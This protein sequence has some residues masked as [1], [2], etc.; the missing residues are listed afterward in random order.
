MIPSSSRH[1]TKNYRDAHLLFFDLAFVREANVAA[2][3]LSDEEIWD[4]LL[5]PHNAA[6][7]RPNAIFD[8]AYY[9]E[10]NGD[11]LSFEMRNPLLHYL[12][13]GEQAGLDPNPYFDLS[14]YALHTGVGTAKYGSLIEHALAQMDGVLPAFHPFVDAEFCFKDTGAADL[15]SF[16]EGLFLGRLN[17][18]KPHPLFDSIFLMGCAPMQLREAFD[19]YW[20][21][22]EDVSTHPLFDIAYYKSQCP[23]GH[24]IG[25]SVYHYLISNTPS[26]PH[27]LFDAQYYSRQFL[28]LKNTPVDSLFEH[29]LTHGKDQE[30]DPSPFFDT[31]FYRAQ[32]GNKSATLQDYVVGGFEKYAPHPL[33]QKPME[34]LLRRSHSAPQAGESPN[35]DWPKDLPMAAT[36]EFDSAIYENQT[37]SKKAPFELRRDYLENGYLKGGKPNNLLAWNYISAQLPD[38]DTCP[39]AV[40]PSYFR[41]GLQNRSRVIFAFQSLDDTPEMRTWLA[42]LE[43]QI[44]HPDLEIIVVTLCHGALTHA[45]SQVSHIWYLGADSDEDAT[46]E[47]LMRSGER[48]RDLLQ[49]NPPEA[50]FVQVSRST[51]LALVLAHLDYPVA[52]FYDTEVG[53][54]ARKTI[55]VL[56]Q[57]RNGVFVTSEQEKLSLKAQGMSAD[58]IHV[59][60]YGNILPEIPITYREAVRKEVRARLGI[61]DDEVLIVSDGGLD[62]EGGVDVFGAVLAQLATHENSSEGLRFLWHGQGVTHAN[63]PLFYAKHFL[64]SVG[65]EGKFIHAE[66]GSLVEFLCASD[67]Y[68]NV[69]RAGEGARGFELAK[70]VGLA[71]VSL[72]KYSEFVDSGG[73]T[74]VIYADAFD[75]NSAVSALSEL[76]ADV[77]SRSEIGANIRA[78]AT[79]EKTVGRSINKVNAALE[80]EYPDFTRFI[81]AEQKIEKTALVLMSPE[82]GRAFPTGEIDVASSRLDSNIHGALTSRGFE[83]ATIVTETRGMRHSKLVGFNYVLCF[84]SGTSK[85]I[86]DIYRFG[87]FFD[88]IIV[89]DMQAIREVEKLNPLISQKMKVAEFGDV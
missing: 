89:G 47:A 36:P 51:D 67:I 75:F 78:I 87:R 85:D 55:S 88:E 61:R 38:A 14:F 42:L 82:D 32:S 43:S 35:L 49:G 25:H 19:Y 40:I 22:E 58:R 34:R 45:F 48:M 71:I 9:T 6:P 50:C 17:P 54:V 4:R 3:D 10:K 44:T 86:Q 79:S 31:I 63:S 15:K 7:F 41:S 77:G 21:A 28:G 59:G 68:L 24:L 11:R 62:L 33:V 60:L 69:R 76:V 53:Q 46:L 20:N 2:R 70:A 52:G 72:R 23:D 73:D 16:Y 37:E 27:P 83:R 5:D 39:E 18:F 12:L 66:E 65:A 30:I 29:Y 64:R 8:V 74:G 1:E 13:E 26:S 57:L 56:E 80:K 84:L 81:H